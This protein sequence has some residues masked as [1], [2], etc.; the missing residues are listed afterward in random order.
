MIRK[1]FKV[2]LLIILLLFLFSAYQWLQTKRELAHYCR[3]TTAGTSLAGARERAL[4]NGFRFIDGSGPVDS[5]KTALVTASG[6]MGR[7]VCE[8]EHD[9]DRVIRASMNKND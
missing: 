4:R 8:I 1:L 3:E 6:I 2:I 7:I 9:G 5:R